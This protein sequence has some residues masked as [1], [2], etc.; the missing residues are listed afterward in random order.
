MAIASRCWSRGISTSGASM[1]F[2]LHQPAANPTSSNPAR[3]GEPVARLPPAVHEVSA[4]DLTLRAL[5][6]ILTDQ[7][8]TE[9]CINRPGEAFIETRE[10]WRCLPLKFADFQWCTSLAKLVANSTRQ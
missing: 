1:S 8:V 3:A 4:L 7:A 5:R 10:G 2:A 6:P 9:L